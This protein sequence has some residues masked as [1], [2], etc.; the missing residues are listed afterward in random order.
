[1]PQI[2]T[3]SLCTLEHE[4]VWR[5]TARLLPRFIPSDDYIVYVPAHER[6][7]FQEIT[8]TPIRVEDE[9]LSGSYAN[10]LSR[11]L[12]I[13]GNTSRYGWYLQQFLKI[14][15]I[16]QSPF[17]LI[18]IW[19]SDCV[20]LRP[21]QLFTETQTA[22][23]LEAYEYHAE[24]FRTIQRLL[25][26]QKARAASFIVPGFPVRKIWVQEMI[27]AIEAKHTGFTWQEAIIQA[28]DLSQASAFSEFET[29]GTWV[30]NQYPT[31]WTTNA[32]S[33]ER[34]GQSRYGYARNLMTDEILKKGR[35]ENLDVISFE[36]WDKPHGWLSQWIKWTSLLVHRFRRSLDI[37]RKYS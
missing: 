28:T 26:L 12:A 5:H 3:I 34:L 25:S 36:N 4:N 19:D 27:Q 1:M 33:W 31:S 16:L 7:A 22:V 30:A 18:V 8:A 37:R 35:D 17:D 29:I 10:A 13:A 24:Y 14:E 15:A 21:I 23:Y 2:Q 11:A 32:I 20:P 9:P 6:A